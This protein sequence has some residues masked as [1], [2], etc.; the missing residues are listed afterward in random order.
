MMQWEKNKIKE[1]YENEKKI[2]AGNIFHAILC[3]SVKITG[4]KPYEIYYQISETILKELAY[5][6]GIDILGNSRHNCKHNSVGYCD[7]QKGNGDFN[8]CQRVC[9]YFEEDK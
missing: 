1:Q 7:I 5:Q 6:H 4:K 9:E 2:L 3:N 8:E